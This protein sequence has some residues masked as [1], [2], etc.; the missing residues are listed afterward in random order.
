MIPCP[1]PISGIVT[2]T[3]DHG[4]MG[5]RRHGQG[6]AAAH[7]WEFQGGKLLPPLQRAR[8]KIMQPQPLTLSVTHY[9]TPNRIVR[10][11]II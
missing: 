8:G 1:P 5:V 11:P 9:Q 4:T 6:W 2:L 3:Y 7:P 10:G